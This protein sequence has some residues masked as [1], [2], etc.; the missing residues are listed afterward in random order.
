MTGPS[1]RDPRRRRATDTQPDVELNAPSVHIDALLKFVVDK[2]AS[3]LHL[4]PGLP[5]MARIDGALVALPN[6]PV[7]SPAMLSGLLD[8]IMTVKQ[9]SVFDAEW[10]LDSLVRKAR[11]R[12]IPRECLHGAW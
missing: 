7:L 1:V 4:T 8:T 12:Q 10:E 11:A 2:N 9:R 6:A 3:D 5:P